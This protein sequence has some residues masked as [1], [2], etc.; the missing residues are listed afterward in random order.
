LFFNSFSSENEKRSDKNKQFREIVHVAWES[1]FKVHWIA[2]NSDLKIVENGFIRL[3]L[4][5]SQIN[6]DNFLRSSELRFISYGIYK[7]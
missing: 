1:R 4:E 3:E 5:H 2:V 6:P 7:I